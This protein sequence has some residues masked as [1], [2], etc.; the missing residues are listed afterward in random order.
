M[1]G[2]G[3]RLLP[4][5]TH[6]GPD[7]YAAK[8]IDS[9]RSVIRSF[10]LGIIFII[11]ALPVSAQEASG[12]QPEAYSNIPVNAEQKQFMI[13][14]SISRETLDLYEKSESGRLVPARQYK[15][16]TAVRGLHIYPLGKGKVT[17]ISFNP[18]WLPHRILPASFSGT[19]Y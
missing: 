12:P 7:I 9:T 13:E 2:N 18:W 10:F 11:L 5:I 14:I 19:G 16:G 8:P 17:A 6:E 15:V 4:I 3:K 1:F